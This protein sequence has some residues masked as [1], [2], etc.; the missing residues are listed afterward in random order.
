MAP[1]ARLQSC[2][3]SRDTDLWYD[4]EKTVGMA[5]DA[6]AR[7]SVRGIGRAGGDIIATTDR[8]PLVRATGDDSDAALIARCKNGDVSAFGELV[9][10]HQRA[11]YGVVCRMIDDKDDV[12]DVVQEVFVQAYRAITSFRGNAA[13]STW[14]YRIAVNTSIKQM[15]KSK[16][17]Q[18][19]SIDDP[20]TGLGDTLQAS[21]VECPEV[22]AE[23]SARD[24]AL[25]EAIDALPE[26]HK[27]VVVLHYFQNLT[28]EDIAKIMECTVGTVWSRLHYACK[29]LQGQLA[30]LNE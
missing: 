26:K 8:S 30:W 18:A 12:D 9:N 4:L 24:R 3:K 11:V 25:K 16:I 14:I 5:T 21:D 13:F 6:P 29:K 1:G 10:R 19:A 28:C 17:R 7:S 22:L 15:K 20:V 23:R 27:A 2:A